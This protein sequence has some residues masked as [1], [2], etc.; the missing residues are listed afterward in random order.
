MDD[1]EKINELEN[2]RKQRVAAILIVVYI[3]FAG[4]GI[5]FVEENVFVGL[6]FGT[7]A[8]GL[9]IPRPVLAA[10]AEYNT[11]AKLSDA[12]K[13]LSNETYNKI[14]KQRFQNQISDQEKELLTPVQKNTAKAAAAGYIGYRVGKGIAKW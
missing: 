3:I 12:K 4:L 10:F 2:I 6:F 9:L 5:S 1:F 8:Y 14:I 13:Y 11:Q 7:I